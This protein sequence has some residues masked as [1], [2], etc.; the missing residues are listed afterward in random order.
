MKKIISILFLS[1]FL[2]GSAYAKVKTVEKNDDYIILKY[3]SL[4]E[5]NVKKHRKLFNKAMMVA[6]DYWIIQ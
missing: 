5:L 1:L 6:A 3:S 4:L 2:S